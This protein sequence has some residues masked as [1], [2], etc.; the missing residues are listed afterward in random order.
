MITTDTTELK[1]LAEQYNISFL[2]LLYLYLPRIVNKVTNNSLFFTSVG[3]DT[4]EWK[5]GEPL[6][7]SAVEAILP[8]AILQNERD[9][10]VFERVYDVS[11]GELLRES[12]KLPSSRNEVTQLIELLPETVDIS[13]ALAIGVANSSS[14]S[15]NEYIS[16]YYTGDYNNTGCFAYGHKI[17][18]VS[19]QITD[20]KCYKLVLDSTYDSYL[21]NDLNLKQKFIG[22]YINNSD[23]IELYFSLSESDCMSYLGNNYIAKDY[24]SKLLGDVVSLTVSVSTGEVLRTK[25]YFL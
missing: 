7:I 22:T 18:T 15:N 20:T 1:K 21:P 6:H 16:V 17:D 2:E 11:N 24:L 19:K 3:T 5:N 12:Y 4:I 10:D 14:V 25:R 8:E 13:N 23:Y 9:I